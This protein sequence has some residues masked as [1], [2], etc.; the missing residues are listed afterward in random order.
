MGAEPDGVLD[1]IRGMPSLSLTLL[2]HQEDAVKFATFL[3][4]MG[5]QPLV[6]V[7]AR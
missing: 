5:V 1:S 3:A 2:P 4:E 7:I 6:P